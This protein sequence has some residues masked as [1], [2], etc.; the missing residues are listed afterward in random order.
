MWTAPNNDK[1]DAVL[2]I[3][4]SI[5]HKF[6]FDLEIFCLTFRR[7]CLLTHVA[8]GGNTLFSW[9]QKV[10]SKSIRTKAVRNKMV[11][12]SMGTRN[13]SSPETEEPCETETES[14]TREER[15][16]RKGRQPQ[17]YSS[18]WGRMHRLQIAHWAK[19]KLINHSV[20]IVCVCWEIPSTHI[21]PTRAESNVA[22]RM[23]LSVPFITSRWPWT[24]ARFP[25]STRTAT[26]EMRTYCM[27]DFSKARVQS[28]RSRLSSRG[29]KVY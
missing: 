9:H 3:I 21:D 4:Y 18:R 1:S 2:K 24:Q 20:L 15:A 11:A 5:V 25:W 19:N 6:I 26:A 12:A 16:T 7:W 23:G 17:N 13:Q 28:T 27:C 29:L 8:I 14:F 10:S 22:E